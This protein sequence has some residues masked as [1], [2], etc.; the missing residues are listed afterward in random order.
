[1]VILETTIF[2]EGKKLIEKLYPAGKSGEFLEKSKRDSLV[3]AIGALAHNRFEDEI[4]SA[5]IGSYQISMISREIQ[6]PGDEEIVKALFMYS[7][8]DTNTDKTQLL[9]NMNEAMDIF[10]NRFSRNDIF[11][12]N[13][14]IFS[15]FAERFD[16]VFEGLIY[17]LKYRLKQ[18]F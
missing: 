2:F 15:S 6:F 9:T 17:S 5:V 3:Q 12:K 14:K 7:I 16:K 10:L 18:I 8:C 1:M 11:E 13:E 4:H